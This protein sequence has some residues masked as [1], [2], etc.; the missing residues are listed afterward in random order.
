MSNVLVDLK[1]VLFYEWVCVD[2]DGV[3]SVGIIEYV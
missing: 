1:Y 2:G 3:Y